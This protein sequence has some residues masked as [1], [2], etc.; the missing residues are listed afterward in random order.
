MSE[1]QPQLEDLK[2]FFGR[3]VHDQARTIVSGWEALQDVHW[4][5]SWFAEF[6]SGVDKLWR[7]ASRYHL[8]PMLSIAA[9]LLR[10][11]EKINPSRVPESSVL[12]QINHSV[13]QIAESCSRVSDERPAQ[14][15]ASGRKPVYFCFSDQS[16]ASSL[17]ERLKHYGIPVS[18]YGTAN[19]LEQSILYRLPIAMVI[20]IDFTEDGLSRIA[21]LRSRLTANIPVIFYSAQE[22][23]IEV[24]LAA[25]R[26]GGVSFL[27]GQLDSSILVEKLIKIYSIGAE[28]P[29]KVLV[30]D[31]SNAQ[32][33]LAERTLNSAGIFTRT[34][35]NPFNILETLD[36]FNPDA[37]LM[38][39]Y[40]PGC[41]GPELAQV[42]RQQ[43]KYDAMPIIYL[44]SESDVE[45]QLEA[46]G[47]G[48]DDFLT[49]PYEKDVLITT[50]LNRCRRYRYLRRQLK[51]DSLTGLLNHKN[52]LLALEKAIELGRQDQMPVCFVMLDIDHFKS[53]NDTYGHGMGDRVI[54]SLA[55]Y[56]RQRFRST[57]KVGRYGGEEFAVVL[58]NTSIEMA[59]NLLEEI[60]EHFSHLVHHHEG[61][62][63]SVTFSCGIACASEGESSLLLSQRT[64]EALYEA[65]SLG[66]NCVHLASV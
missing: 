30:V 4:N 27:V 23:S 40:M 32:A 49:K 48:G 8:A 59:Q 53:V 50:V 11:L 28:R 44:S 60:R 46:V 26:N 58:P 19:E 6:S 9:N 52:I 39:M 57:D 5:E 12:E 56:L 2:V 16:L 54:S 31:D 55:L 66:R 18:C 33:A 64:D 63:V 38:D 13:M 42:L 37:V 65:K 34:V 10:L 7:L 3:R 47:H 24:R 36:S 17:Q 51:T 29:F 20:D 22:P 45:K 61:S 41:T 21:E 25:V 14:Q 15:I 1:K 43:S 62:E 35:T